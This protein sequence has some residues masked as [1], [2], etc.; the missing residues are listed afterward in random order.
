M[1]QLSSDTVQRIKATILFISEMFKVLMATLL[2]VFVPQ[3]CADDH[4]IIENLNSTST[5]N[6]E[7][8]Q[9]FACT[10]SDNFSNLSGFNIAV[11]AI[12]FVTLGSFL[13]MY[14]I[15]YVRENWCIKY[16]DMDNNKANTNLKNEIENYPEI[17]KNLILLNKHYYNNIIVLLICNLANFVVSSVL[18]YK[19][20]YLDY[21]SITVLLTNV[22]L[23]ADKLVFSLNTA[24]SSIKETLPFSA[25]IKVPAVYNTIDEDFVIKPKDIES[26]TINSMNSNPMIK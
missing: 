16:L 20:Y 9:D 21:R 24:N 4:P 18:I 19:F 5:N 3:S 25:Y 14:I 22:L 17:K 26:N 8:N 15:E 12:N 2:S 7:E 23:I 1:K 13:S 11:L 10:M 6:T